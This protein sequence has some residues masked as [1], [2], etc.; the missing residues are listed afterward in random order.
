LDEDSIEKI[1]EQTS[2]SCPVELVEENYEF[3]AED[4]VDNP[5]LKITAVVR[6]KIQ[7]PCDANTAKDAQDGTYIDCPNELMDE[8]YDFIFDDAD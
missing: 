2:I 5:C 6:I 3:E 4:D 7:D 1:K 8:N